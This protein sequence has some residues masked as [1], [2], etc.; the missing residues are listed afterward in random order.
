MLRGDGSRIDPDTQVYYLDNSK[1]GYKHPVMGAQAYLVSHGTAY[2]QVWIQHQRRSTHG[3]IACL[4]DQLRYELGMDSWRLQWCTTNGDNTIYVRPHL[5]AVEST[6][7][8]INDPQYCAAHRKQM[9]LCFMLGASVS[10]ASS[11][12]T[13][14]TASGQRRYLPPYEIMRNTHHT[15]IPAKLLDTWFQDCSPWYTLYNMA[16]ERWPELAKSSNPVAAVRTKYYQLINTII[17]RVDGR[18]SW[19]LAD[20]MKRLDDIISYVY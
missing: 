16:V 14:V 13:W 12:M 10:K 17:D 7:N 6:D 3:A 18:L 8:N 20:S 2:A 19:L 9:A 11:M 15:L 4:I 5:E 1:D